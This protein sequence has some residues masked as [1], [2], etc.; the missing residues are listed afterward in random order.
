MARPLIEFQ[1]GGRKLLRNYFGLFLK[2]RDA[3]G[4]RR[5]WNWESGSIRS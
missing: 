5:Y 1:Q 2:S 4:W 3:A